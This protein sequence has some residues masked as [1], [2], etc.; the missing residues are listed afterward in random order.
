MATNV[1]WK[2]QRQASQMHL[3]IWRSTAA[4]V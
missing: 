4:G 2:N 3:A 1:V